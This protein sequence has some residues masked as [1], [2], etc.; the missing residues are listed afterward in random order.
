MNYNKEVD[1]GGENK[2]KEVN[3]NYIK[4]GINKRRVQPP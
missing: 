3:F 4:K 1:E 2:I